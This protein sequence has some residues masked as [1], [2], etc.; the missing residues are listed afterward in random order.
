MSTSTRD[1]HF[2]DCPSCKAFA[3]LRLFERK[4][5]HSH[6]HE[7]VCSECQGRFDEDVVEQESAKRATR[8]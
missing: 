1:P 6:K 4:E 7:Y 2:F 3:T 8:K 5:R